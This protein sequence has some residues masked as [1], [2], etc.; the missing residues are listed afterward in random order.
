M[1]KTIARG[2]QLLIVE[3]EDWHTLYEAERQELEKR[4][5]AQFAALEHVGSTAIPGLA[6]KP[7]I[8]I[9]AGAASLQDPAIGERLG[10]M[11]Y[12][13]IPF[14]PA[15]A[16]GEATAGER[17]FFLKRT[18]ETAEG[19]D[20]SHPG[21]NIH[22]VPMARF[23]REDQLLFRDHLRARPDLVADYARLK[24]ELAGRI[25]DYREYAPAKSAFIEQVLRAAR[26]A[27]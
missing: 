4:L 14:R 7:V 23:R 6:G 25:A 21:F 13:Q 18:A 19:A 26:E 15:T 12:V 20:A 9:L 11:G 1:A 5:G 17:L 10:A 22:V 16:G 2:P 3:R 8:D 24:C 27:P